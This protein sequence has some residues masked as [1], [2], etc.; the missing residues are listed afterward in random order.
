MTIQ[1]GTM[2]EATLAT[3]TG[4]ETL[5]GR[6]TVAGEGSMS[7]EGMITV[8]HVTGLPTPV[9]VEEPAT[10]SMPNTTRGRFHSVTVLG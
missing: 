8:A 1:P 5:V 7:V 4:T 3:H 2:V 10:R 6:V 9:E